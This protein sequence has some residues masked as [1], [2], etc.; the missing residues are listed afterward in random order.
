MQ[1]NAR[2][3]LRVFATPT[4]LIVIPTQLQSAA[5]GTSSQLVIDCKSFQSRNMS[6]F[7]PFEQGA[8][9]S[10]IRVYESFGFLG[11]MKIDERSTF[12]LLIT[13]TRSVGVFGAF[14]FFQVVKTAFVPAGVFET[15]EDMQRQLAGLKKVGI[16]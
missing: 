5:A 6:N 12:A 3:S 7:N 2:C 8:K 11:L 15:R 14:E 1:A 4:H 13:K 10:D 16:T 9:C